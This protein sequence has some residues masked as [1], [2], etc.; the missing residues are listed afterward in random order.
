MRSVDTR[1]LED[2][3][4]KDLGSVGKSWIRES[5]LTERAYLSGLLT[6]LEFMEAD[7]K[8]LEGFAVRMVFTTLHPRKRDTPDN[9][10]ASTK[11]G[12]L[13]DALHAELRKPDLAYKTIQTLCADIRESLNAYRLKTDGLLWSPLPAARLTSDEPARF[14]RRL[15]ALERAAT[16]VGLF[17]G[18][19]EDDMTEIG[20]I[21]VAY[22]LCNVVA[23]WL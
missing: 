8:Q 17:G 15:L 6:G 4:H 2:T 22:C 23:A 14:V 12:R 13:M 5:A 20:C 1:Q 7:P 18:D 9:P 11:F 3:V 19:G 21:K 16:I 10:S